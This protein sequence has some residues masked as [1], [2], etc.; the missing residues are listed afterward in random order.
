MKVCPDC[1]EEIEDEELDWC[2]EVLGSGTQPGVCS[3]CAEYYQNLEDQFE[4]E[5]E[6]SLRTD[7][8]FD[9]EDGE[10]S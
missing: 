1:S 8:E 3:E 5:F 10:S 4:D 2:P 7:S 6:S 9:F